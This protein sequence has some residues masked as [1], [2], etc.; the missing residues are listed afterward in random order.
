MDVAILH[1]IHRLKVSV[2][3]RQVFA[4]RAHVNVVRLNLHAV[5]NQFHGHLRVPREELGQEG[6]VAGGL[7]RHDYERKSGIGGR[8]VEERLEGFETT[9]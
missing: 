8:C 5:Y 1:G 9:G 7:V 3:D 6:D 4:R 2:E